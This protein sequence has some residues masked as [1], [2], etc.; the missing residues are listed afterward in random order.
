MEP[1]SNF[2]HFIAYFVPGV[3]L[4]VAFMMAGSLLAA[5][6]LLNDSQIQ[7]L[8]VI[9]VLGT[10]LGLFVDELRHK[11]FEATLEHEWARKRRYDPA[12]ISDPILYAK[13]IGLE[14]YQQIVDDYYYFYEFD[15][16]IAVALAFSAMVAPLFLRVFY[17][18]SNSIVAVLTTILLLLA[19]AFYSFGVQC[20]EYFLDLMVQVMD[21]VDKNFLTSIKLP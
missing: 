19:F 12:K 4:A 16:N 10:I 21:K 13:Q 17:G 11:H 20:Y 9:V 1:F 15:T 5:T 14:I 6:N 8:I 7:N 3:V 18:A 2:G